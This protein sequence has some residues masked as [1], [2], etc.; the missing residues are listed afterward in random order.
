ML[1]A[2]VVSIEMDDIFP[3][4]LHALWRLLHAHQD[5]V[6]LHRIHP[7]LFPGTVR[8]ESGEA[9][10]AGRTFHTERV[11]E[12]EVRWL[13]VVRTTWTYKI[14][15]PDRFDYALT[16]ADGSSLRFENRYTPATGGTRVTTRGA[17]DLRGIPKFMQGP[18]TRRSLS[19]TDREDVAFLNRMEAPSPED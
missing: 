14:D 7:D 17:V 15:P 11:I 4:P 1:D 13:R 3:A 5:E 12:R 16:A 10:F 18:L 8:S 19:R 6:V 9:A 2:P